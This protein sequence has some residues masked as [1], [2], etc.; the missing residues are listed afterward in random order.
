MSSCWWHQHSCVVEFDEFSREKP[1]QW[2]E[3][4]ISKNSYH[5]VKRRLNNSSSF[6]S[7]AVTLLIYSGGQITKSVTFFLTV[8]VVDEKNKKR[9]RG[10]VVMIVEL[11]FLVSGCIQ[12]SIQI[13]NLDVWGYFFFL[14]SDLFPSEK[15]MFPY[16]PK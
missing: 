9:K 12:S 1:V 5:Y 16:W 7:W 11:F 15:G 4:F 2:E 8:S 10:F 6:I 3:V 13:N 14:R